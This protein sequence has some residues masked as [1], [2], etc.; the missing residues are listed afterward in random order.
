MSK[1][2][3]L[4]LWCLSGGLMV[5]ASTRAAAA[6][7]EHLPA[8]TVAAAPATAHAALEAEASSLTAR[9]APVFVQHTAT[10]HAERD[11]PLPVD[12]D[13]DW[14][15]TNNWNHATPAA[16]RTKPVVYGSAI[17][18]TT[19][20]F[21]TYTLF[22]PRDWQPVLCVPYAC[23][24]NDLEVV[25]VVVERNAADSGDPLCFVETKAHRSYVALRGADVA[26]AS[27]RRPLIEVESQG[28]GMYALQPGI[29]AEGAQT[30]FAPESMGAALQP[31]AEAPLERYAVAS[32]HATLWA[33]RSPTSENGHL[34]TEGESGW[35]SYA[36]AR[37]GRRGR[38]LGA[39]MAGKEFAGG[40]RPPWALKAEGARGDWFL[41]P[42]LSALR[43]HGSWFS[44]RRP[45]EAT[46]V[47]NPYLDE[48][49]A[50]CVGSA[51]PAPVKAH[52]TLALSP[53]LVGLLLALGLASRRF[54][55]RAA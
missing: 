15:A 13:G 9:W 41:D 37:F 46:Y 53:T 49:A 44:P 26:R 36:G 38:A 47:L 33:R 43:S 32:L 5:G 11:R 28:H 6:P 21:L 50:E 45:L 51:C 14:D 19:H 23:H 35:L 39:S 52:S 7:A 8:T 24:D 40:V 27:D 2:R 30:W 22:F 29:A 18:T 1:L 42:A 55:R 4:S 17:L 10:D 48:L 16:A 20:A 34:W 25:L 3:V 54:R 12:F 31:P